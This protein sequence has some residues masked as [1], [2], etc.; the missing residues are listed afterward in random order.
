MND[1][2][3]GLNKDRRGFRKILKMVVDNM[4][5][6]VTVAYPDRLTRFGFKT[7]GYFFKIYGT[8]VIVIN[9]VD[10]TPQE[11]LVDDL[12]MIISHFAGMVCVATDILSRFTY[13]HIY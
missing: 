7:L 5:S 12:I 1:I 6:K 8:E 9:H 4:V 10:K 13:L 2:G 11:E 3:S